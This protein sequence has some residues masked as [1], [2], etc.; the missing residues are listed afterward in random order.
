M[1]GFPAGIKNLF[2]LTVKNPPE[3]I[4]WS[5]PG[6]FFSDL[7]KKDLEFPSLKNPV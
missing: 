7:G 5:F 4:L 2:H 6:H 3:G 1:I